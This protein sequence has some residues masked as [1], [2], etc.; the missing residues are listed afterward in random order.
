MI[1]SLLQFGPSNR[2]QGKRNKR[3]TITRENEHKKQTTIPV[4]DK[5]K[6]KTSRAKEPKKAKAKKREKKRNQRVASILFAH[7]L[8]THH[9]PRSS[10]YLSKQ[11]FQ[12]QIPFFKPVS[13]PW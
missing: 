3:N 10:L 11:G 4:D 2:N 13:I 1:P 5:A 6:N 9:P 12:I 8:N 7:K